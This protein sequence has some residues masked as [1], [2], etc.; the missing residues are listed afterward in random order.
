MNIY[1]GTE[2]GEGTRDKRVEKSLAWTVGEKDV[3]LA[4]IRF[5]TSI[6]LMDTL[7]FATLE[8]FL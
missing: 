3:T 4:F 7:N 8:T 6:H 1:T 5:F 2:P